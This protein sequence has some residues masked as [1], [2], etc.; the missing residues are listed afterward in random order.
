VRLGRRW[1]IGKFTFSL[2]EHMKRT[3]IA[4]VA[5][6]GA[7]AL[8]GASVSSSATPSTETRSAHVISWKLHELT[9]YQVG[10]NAFTGTDVIRSRKTH[11]VL[12]YNAGTA[13]FLPAQ[14]VLKL[15]I[16]FAVKGGL[17]VVRMSG[18]FDESDVFTGRV[19]SGTGD[20][21]GISGTV[22]ARSQPSND[23]VTFVTLR[24][25]Y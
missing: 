14:N 11:K 22:T 15:D 4:A 2:E 19:L 5:L 21:K 6:A 18:D 16:A 24:V 25:N 7:T 3:A 10:D 9:N 1:K 23:A 12:G 17:I 20:F 13:K 8:T